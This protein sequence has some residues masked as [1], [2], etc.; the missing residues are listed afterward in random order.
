MKIKKYLVEKFK[1]VP[2][3][4]TGLFELQMVLNNL[5]ENFSESIVKHAFV[6]ARSLMRLAHKFK[7]IEENPAD[8]M[9]MP[10]TKPV[11]RPTMSAEL[12]IK[13]VDAIGSARFVSDE[14]RSLLCHSYQR[15]LRIAVE[16]VRRDRLI[17]HSTAYEGKLY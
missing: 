2:L 1:G 9:R 12:I 17:I 4:E 16:V 10:D 8:N 7:F 3:R 14:Y 5:A 11:E 13:L 6:N 15:N